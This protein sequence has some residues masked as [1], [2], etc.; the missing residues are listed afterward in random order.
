[1]DTN[2][3]VVDNFYDNVDEVR[4]FA[5]A[6]EYDVK[7]NYP[8]NRTKSFASNISV[9]ETIQRILSPLGKISNWPTVNSYN[10]AFQITTA[11]DR[12]WI[13][14]DATT[15]WA[16]VCYLTPNA[17]LEGGTGFY[18][19]KSTGELSSNDYYVDNAQDLSKWELVSSVGNV[20]NRLI[21]YRAT[22]YHSSMDYFG[23]DLQDGRL[24]QT[25][26]FDIK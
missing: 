20:Y 12:S 26:F 22:Q 19:L 18:K 6:Q 16:G 23:K 11:S 13:H 4:S 5:L 24:F 17:P 3:I 1:M 21:L 2:T 25:F 10:G 14:S 8:G 9:K 15:G 7:G